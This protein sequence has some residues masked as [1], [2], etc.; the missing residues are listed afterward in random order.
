MWLLFH[1]WVITDKCHG[2][3]K[4]SE[5]EY[6][7]TEADK[8]LHSQKYLN[9]K[10]FII[11]GLSKS[12]VVMLGLDY[13]SKSGN[14]ERLVGLLLCLKQF[15]GHLPPSRE[16]DQNDSIEDD[17]FVSTILDRVQPD[18]IARLICT[19]NDIARSAGVSFLA[20]VRGHHL[21]AFERHHN[22]II[23]NEFRDAFIDRVDSALVIDFIER[24][25]NGNEAVRSFISEALLLPRITKVLRPVRVLSLIARLST[26]LSGALLELTPDKAALLRSLVVQCMYGGGSGQEELRGEMLQ[27]TAALLPSIRGDWT[28]EE[29]PSIRGTFARLLC[30]I[31][32]GELQLL[33][34]T[35][36]C[37]EEGALV[38]N[39]E[40]VI[41][42]VTA[43]SRLIDG[44]LG[45]MIGSQEADD[46]ENKGEGGGCWDQL[47]PEA[48]LAVQRDVHGVFADLMGFLAESPPLA[49]ANAASVRA[50]TTSLCR[51]ALFDDSLLR[52]V[53]SNLP[54]LLRFSRP[55]L[56]ADTG[57]D[58][59]P[60][61][62]QLVRDLVH[63]D[64]ESLVY[65]E[66][67][68]AALDSGSLL[69]HAVRRA[70]ALVDYVSSSSAPVS[71]TT[72]E[73][74]TLTL[75]VCGV[76]MTARRPEAELLR[77]GEGSAGWEPLLGLTA[78]D[79]RQLLR[80]AQALLAGNELAISGRSGFRDSC[81]AVITLAQALLI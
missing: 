22:S 30:S 9:V 17:E 80:S 14:E 29:E 66:L 7:P 8:L 45:L 15:E 28:V 16:G 79:L 39:E 42:T 33:L 47:P 46:D 73:D 5:E 12:V 50:L 60:P 78:S 13:L 54:R 59:L 74:A 6:G 52:L 1:V 69:S 63:A 76:L 68:D 32:R 37:L 21:A 31:L 3:L 2:I 24:G 81:Y 44:V 64:S 27:A 55:S 75:D 19:E 10:N 38:V 40:D 57:T 11:D 71:M 18:F 26:R 20:L 34:E 53:A 56:S 36:L 67:L 4:Y 58:V 77:R 43:G 48:L 25:L 70:A 23:G 41:E 62:L 61:L 65:E 49:L 51:W 35:R 72:L